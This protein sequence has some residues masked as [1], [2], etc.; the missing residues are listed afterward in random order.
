MTKPWLQKSAESGHDQAQVELAKMYRDGLGVEQ[1]STEAF[2]WFQ[3]AALQGNPDAEE[4][5]SF[6]CALDEPKDLIEACMWVT[7]ANDKDPRTAD[8]TLKILKRAGI[9][10]SS[11]Q[12]E[13]GRQRAEEFVKTNHFALPPTNQV[14]GL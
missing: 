11:E 9:V 7:L 1:N 3:K 2:D 8:I 12:I 5:M 6:H 4:N 14:N 10:F 13:A